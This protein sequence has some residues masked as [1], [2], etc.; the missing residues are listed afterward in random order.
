MIFAVRCP[1]LPTSHLHPNTVLLSFLFLFLLPLLISLLS[2]LSASQHH[3]QDNNWLSRTCLSEGTWLWQGTSQGSQ[4]LP[5]LGSVVSHHPES[6][7]DFFIP[8]VGMHLSPFYPHTIL[9]YLWAN[10]VVSNNCKRL[11]INLAK[12]WCRELGVAP[13]FHAVTWSCMAASERSSSTSLMARALL[14][15]FLASSTPQ[16]LGTANYIIEDINYND[17]TF[18]PHSCSGYQLVCL[19]G[20]CTNDAAFVCWMWVTSLTV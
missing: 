7:Q 10:L 9:P 16:H 4:F 5:L 3:N 8:R 13:H 6:S 15:L 2:W 12:A 1:Q 17:F 14:R 11:H 19:E 18:S 20:I